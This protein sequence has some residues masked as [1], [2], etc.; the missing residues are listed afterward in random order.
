MF[1]D[2]FGAL[3]L[4]DRT[5]DDAVLNLMMVFARATNTEGELLV[6]TCLW[7]LRGDPV[8][9]EALEDAVGGP[10]KNRCTK[11]EPGP[12]I[13]PKRCTFAHDHEGQHSIDM[14][15]VEKCG[16]PS[17]AGF[18]TLPPC[19]KPKGHEGL[20]HVVETP[21]PAGERC[22]KP[23]KGGFFTLQCTKTKDHEGE[24]K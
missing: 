6:Q 5:K 3:G 20:C 8:A 15:E 21:E 24:C 11:R 16:N 9:R 19:D 18:F 7:V 10:N 4:G 12:Y 1:G 22:P 2:I 14:P 23:Y 13:R 17:R